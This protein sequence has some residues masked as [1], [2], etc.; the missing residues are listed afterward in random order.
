MSKKTKLKNYE[1]LVVGYC[2]VLVVGAEDEA[3]AREMA[4]S[5]VDSGDLEIDELKIEDEVAASHLATARNHADVI[6]DDPD[7]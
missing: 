5:E 1:V 2:R 3:H 7:V 6:A 4:Q